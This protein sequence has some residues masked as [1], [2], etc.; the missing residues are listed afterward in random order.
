MI[1]LFFIIAVVVSLPVAAIVLVSVASKR[2][3]RRFSLGGQADG[4]VQE[5]ARRI[6]DFHT[7]SR[8]DWMPASDTEPS[9][10]ARQARPRKRIDSPLQATRMMSFRHAA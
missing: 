7:E 6:L 2:E 10:P 3:D 1:I 8:S 9:S 4:R 5:T